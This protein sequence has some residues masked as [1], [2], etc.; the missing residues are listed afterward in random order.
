MALLA[1][2]LR[3]LLLPGDGLEDTDSAACPSMV[4]PLAAESH[5]QAADRLWLSGTAGMW[6]W[7]ELDGHRAAVHGCM[8]VCVTA[9]NSL[10]CCVAQ[11]Y[12]V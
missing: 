7:H 12:T 4:E 6:K 3:P 11:H 2:A 9:R 10:E 8:T 5:C 1:T